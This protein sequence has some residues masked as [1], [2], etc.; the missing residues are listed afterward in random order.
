MSEPTGS[1]TNLRRVLITG[2]SGFIG[3]NAV[4]A[5]AADQW[6][7]CSVD[8]APPK[9]EAHRS[10]W[11]PVDILD[12]LAVAEVF[13]EFRPALVI[14]LAARTD[15]DEHQRIEGYAANIAGVANVIRAISETPG[16][17]RSIFASSRLV[18]D[19]GHLPKDDRDYHA[20]TLYGQSKARG[21][22]LVHA[23]GP[24]LGTWSIVRPTG[25]WGPWFG[26]P[27]R[28]FFSTVRRGLYMHP[29]RLEVRK[30]YGYVGNTIYQLRAI[31]SA[32]RTAVDKKT[33]WL[34]DP[35]VIVREW[36]EQIRMAFG[37]PG[38]RTVPISVL[39]LGGTL[40]DAAKRL[41]LRRIPLSGFRV[42]NMVTDMIYTDDAL[43]ALVGPLPW[44]PTHGVATT[45]RWILA[46]EAEA[47]ASLANG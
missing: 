6:N 30:S 21:E 4:D 19:L 38:I 29:G 13:A 28:D 20:T 17:E 34:A 42:N 25:I 36:A 44:T 47:K 41:G 7:V 27:Y 15:L 1:T 16:V 18:F 39:R 31:A 46:E 9:A 43:A 33:F 40:G 35:P 37:A 24:E 14:H 26:I 32:E 23:A 12:R 11:R 2:G 45:V 10:L 3:T 22:Q 8:I 5:F